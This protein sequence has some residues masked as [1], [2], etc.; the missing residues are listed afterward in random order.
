M[1][2]VLAS[3]EAAESANIFLHTGLVWEL[4]SRLSSMMGMVRV[5]PSVWVLD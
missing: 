2:V 4:A 3:V 1:A 5:A